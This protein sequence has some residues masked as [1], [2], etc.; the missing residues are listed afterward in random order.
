MLHARRASF[1]AEEN[2]V[3][4]SFSHQPQ[5]VGIDTVCAGTAR[6]FKVRASINH[7]VTEIL[8]F[9]PVNGEHVVHQIKPFYAIHA[10][11]QAHFFEHAR[12]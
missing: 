7:S 3:A 12:R 10:V 5:E 6:P 9:S 11:Q 4:T 8:N 1:D 2:V